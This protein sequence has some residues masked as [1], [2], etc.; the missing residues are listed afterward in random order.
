MEWA[1][2]RVC[3]HSAEGT[4]GHHGGRRGSRQQPGLRWRSTSRQTAV[5]YRD[6]RGVRDARGALDDPGSCG[7]RESGGELICVGVNDDGMVR[8]RSELMYVSHRQAEA[9]QELR[10]DGV[11][12]R[13]DVEED[14]RL[15]RLGRCRRRIGIGVSTIPKSRRNCDSRWTWANIQMGFERSVLFLGRLAPC[16]IL[17][18][19]FALRCSDVS[20]VFVRLRTAATVTPLALNGGGSTEHWARVHRQR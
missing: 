6:V 5:L 9:V 19:W 17:N 3:T 1:P 15:I 7:P 11:V 16:P 2:I 8:Q 4:E 12:N 14:A 20:Y 13:G 10:C 18:C